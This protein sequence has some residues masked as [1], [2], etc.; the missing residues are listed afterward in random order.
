V[1]SYRVVRLL[2]NLVGEAKAPDITPVY[3]TRRKSSGMV[4]RLDPFYEVDWLDAFSTKWT[5]VAVTRLSYS[6]DNLGA[7]YQSSEPVFAPIDAAESKV[8]TS[9]GIRCVASLAQFHQLTTFQLASLLDVRAIDVD[10]A[11]RD[12]F[13]YGVVENA[14]PKW[15]EREAQGRKQSGSGFLW[16]LSNVT[17]RLELWMSR[18]TDIEAKLVA[19]GR[20]IAVGTNS[21]RSGSSIR[22]NLSAS[23]LV[24]R[25]MESCPAVIGAWGETATVGKL[26]LS[27]DIKKRHDLRENIGDA[28]L[29][30]KD[31]A[32]IVFETS[33]ATNLDDKGGDKLELKAAAWASIAALSDMDLKIVFVNINS[34][35]R[36]A[37][38]EERVTK[39][40]DKIGKSITNI[41][42]QKK[43]VESVFTANAYD[44]FPMP[45]TTS[46]GFSSL[47]VF[48]PKSKRYYD[49]APARTQFNV[50]SDAMVNTVAALHTPSWVLRRL[51]SEITNTK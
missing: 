13:S 35:A 14:V 51:T 32:I 40:L 3:Q 18:L 19:Q 48:H 43:G 24:L 31:G 44:W 38:F 2:S 10:R 9:V 1:Q 50:E 23:E 21:S 17:E 33:G 37:K 29:V 46:K 39:G 28:A 4:D 5:Q 16:R 6:F 41:N 11:M 36:M 34:S 22:H 26:F 49:L 47:Q 30:T 20:D 27:D 45:L 8:Y 15:L 7:L 12:L 25:A 42:L